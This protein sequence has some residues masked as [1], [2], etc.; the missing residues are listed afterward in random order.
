MS[1]K[2]LKDIIKLAVEQL[3]GKIPYKT[4]EEIDKIEL[5]PEYTVR[6]T[7]DIFCFCPSKKSFVK[8]TRGQK[9]FIIDDERLDPEKF[10]VYTWDG[11]L[12]EI[13]VDELI[14]TGFD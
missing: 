9:V 10:L 13:H 6:G 1:K 12:V 11:F 2:N 14:E 5:L 3:N 8:I 4:Q 7:G